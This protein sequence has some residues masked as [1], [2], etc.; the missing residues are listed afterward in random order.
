MNDSY[1]S[2]VIGRPCQGGMNAVCE[3]GYLAHELVQLHIL[4]VLPPLP[5]LLSV[6]RGDGQVANRGVEPHVE[7]LGDDMT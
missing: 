6:P 3:S 7:H 4:R 1:M 5:P 2:I